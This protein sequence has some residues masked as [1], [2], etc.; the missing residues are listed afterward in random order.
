MVSQIIHFVWVII[1]TGFGGPFLVMKSSLDTSGRLRADG[2]IISILLDGL[3]FY[4]N[5]GY[6]LGANGLSVFCQF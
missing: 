5:F 4:F 1:H 3:H 6:R 2:L